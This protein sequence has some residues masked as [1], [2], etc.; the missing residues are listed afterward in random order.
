VTVR[1]ASIAAGVAIAISSLSANVMSARDALT[2][3]RNYLV[4]WQDTLTNLVVEE[5]YRQEVSEYRGGA[6]AGVVRTRRLHSEVLLVQAPADN[7]WL[8]F[9]DVM[10]VDG[11]PVRDRQR[12]FDDLFAGPVA[13]M[14]STAEKIAEEGIRYNLGRAHR[15]VNA[16]FA[17]LVFLHPKYD[18]NTVWKL[19]ANA[20]LDGKPVWD[21]EFVQRTPPF[22]VQVPP[23][24]S[25][26]SSGRF[27]LEPQTGRIIEWELTVI[28]NRSRF[29]ARTRFGAVREIEH[30]WVPLEMEDSYEVPR[31]ERLRA[32]ATYS[33]YRLFRTGA[34]VI[35][36]AS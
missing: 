19:D 1:T 5:E 12:R 8:S 7:T 11:T 32:V 30:G 20:R 29:R 10:A 14:L 33:N 25:H 15:T 18:A 22:A 26:Q 17:A 4:V 31:L 27:R 21:L 35:G 2:L 34:K 36:P 9:R 28:M 16:P 6:P 23:N 13:M 24:T 3:A